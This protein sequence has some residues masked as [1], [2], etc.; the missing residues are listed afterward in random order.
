MSEI[1]GSRDSDDEE[2]TFWSHLSPKPQAYA[3]ILHKREI[4]KVTPR[5]NLR[6][7]QSL[8]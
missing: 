5:E 1:K 8:E 2:T 6:S 3:F 4:I 7:Q